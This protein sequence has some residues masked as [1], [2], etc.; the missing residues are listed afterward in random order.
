MVVSCMRQRAASIPWRARGR[1]PAACLGCF[2]SYRKYAMHCLHRRKI[3][4]IHKCI[5]KKYEFTN[6]HAKSF[7]FACE[8]LL[9]KSCLANTLPCS[10]AGL[11]RFFAFVRLFSLHI[12]LCADAG[13][14]RFPSLF[15]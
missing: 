10:A 12:R 15:L 3:G 4:R 14:V 9:L 5:F 2:S 13:V 7:C 11:L 6:T 8:I 1:A